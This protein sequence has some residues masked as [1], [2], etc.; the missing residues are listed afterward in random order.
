MLSLLRKAYALLPWI[1][2]DPASDADHVAFR[3]SLLRFAV[4]IKCNICP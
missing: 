2:I 1:E 3:S 4:S